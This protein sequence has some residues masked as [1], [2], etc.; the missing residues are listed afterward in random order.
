M[1][2]LRLDRFAVAL[3]VGGCGRRQQEGPPGPP[4]PVIVAPVDVPAAV[5]VPTAV[6]VPAAVDVPLAP[7]PDAVLLRGLADGSVD[8]A[9]HVDPTHGVVLVTYVEAGP[10]GEAPAR[11]QTRGLCGAAATG[12][13][14]LR[15]RLRSAAGRAATEGFECEGDECLVPGMEYQP[16]YRWRLGRRADGARVLLGA[17]EISEAA[18][19]D[20]WLVPA[21]AYVERAMV[22]ARARPCA[23]R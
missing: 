2:R 13:A 9:A 23:G 19:R 10:S 4:A 15:A 3:L 7:S 17:I 21:R 8:L 22:A 1:T 11:H 16:T 5:D 6:D 18:L 20:E 12:D 14:A